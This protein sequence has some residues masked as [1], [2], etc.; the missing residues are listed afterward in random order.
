MIPTIRETKIWIKFRVVRIKLSFFQFECNCSV[1]TCKWV[2]RDPI[3]AC[4]WIDHERELQSL[5]ARVVPA[6]KS[7]TDQ[8]LREKLY[9][10]WFQPVSGVLTLWV[11][12]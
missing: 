12:N 2:D 6:T 7:Q 1:A 11:A 8:T 4:K 3:A 5:V 9:F 10:D